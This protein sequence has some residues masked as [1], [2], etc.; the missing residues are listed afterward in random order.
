MVVGCRWPISAVR[1]HP[2]NCVIDSWY[3]SFLRLLKKLFARLEDSIYRA[4]IHRR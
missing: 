2:L 3:M 4:D 1:D